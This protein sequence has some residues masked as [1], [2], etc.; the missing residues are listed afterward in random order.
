MKI[1][2]E[3]LAR[4]VN[5]DRVFARWELIHPFCPKWNREAEQQ[6]GFDQNH[7]KFQ[8]R[9]DAAFNT[10]MIGGGMASFPETNQ[11][12]NEERRPAEKERPH[13]P[14]AELEDVVDLIPMGGSVRR[15]TEEFINQRQATHLLSSSS[16]IS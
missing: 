11:N 8:M 2:A 12:E 7:A 15:L 1:P 13:E 5:K 3:L 6:N 10:S 4:N 9:G 16:I 14:V